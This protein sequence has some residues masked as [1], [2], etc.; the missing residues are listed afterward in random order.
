MTVPWTPERDAAEVD[1]LVADRYLENL[2][3][4]AD[5]HAIDA[6]ADASLDPDLRRAARV[7]QGALVRVH[8]SFRF[9]ERLAARL[10]ELAAVHA[11][12]S[13]TQALAAGSAGAGTLV[14]FP[15]SRAGIATDPLL[16][17]VLS[18]ALDPA[19]EEA[20]ARA[21][22]EPV[23]R[24]PLL[25]VGSAAITS[26]ALSLVGVAWVAWRA[27]RG[28]ARTVEALMRRAARTAHARRAARTALAGAGLGGP[29]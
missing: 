28:D 4:A 3:A 16:D 5:R 18:G 21:E 13:G 20:I 2:L 11:A 26:A 27:S 19:D 29:A 7:L 15:G 14:P 24:A 10:G 23:R 6:P 9:E 12:P 25:V 8:P 17:A 1:A 22:G